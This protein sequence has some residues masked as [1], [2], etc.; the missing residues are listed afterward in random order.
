M[1]TKK[2]K[3]LRLLVTKKC[4]KSC[5]GCCNKDWNLDIL[6]E[7]THFNY[8]EIILTGGEPML[9]HEQ[10]L[11]I[12]KYIRCISKAK[13]IVYTADVSDS[14]KFMTLL[15]SIDGITVTLHEQ[16]DVE[17][18]YRLI[19]FLTTFNYSTKKQIFKKS[20]RLNIFKDIDYTNLDTIDWIVKD[21]IEWIKNCPLPRNEIFQR[22]KLIK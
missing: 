20:L 6:P 21:N 5:P 9:V 8:N 15:L 1:Q 14:W 4:N 2:V 13:I 17:D 16:K 10:L 3:T 7:V 18:F 22:L 12:I 11:T 19:Q